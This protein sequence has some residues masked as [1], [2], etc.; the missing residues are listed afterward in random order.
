MILVYYSLGGNVERFCQNTGL[1]SIE[2]TET[3]P[4]FEI[5]VDYVLV[6][7]TYDAIATES[8][9]D[10]LNTG[11][12]A[13]NCVGIAGSGNINFDDL[14]IFTAKDLSKEFNIPIIYDFEYFGTKR[15]VENFKREVEKLEVSKT[16]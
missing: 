4:F 11:N 3:N 10:F 1:I 6:V 8:I 14:Y 12:N 13:K 15:D 5:P 9:W 2:I 7:P 16:N